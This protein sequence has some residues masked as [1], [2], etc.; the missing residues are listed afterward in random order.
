[1]IVEI[2]LSLS[3]KAR[4]FDIPDYLPCSESSQMLAKRVFDIDVILISSN[5]THVEP[6]YKKNQ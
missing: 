5:N 4:I 3:S 2:V 6:Q 1:V